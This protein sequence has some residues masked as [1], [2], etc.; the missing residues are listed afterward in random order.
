M[1]FRT[2][3]KETIEDWESDPGERNRP[4]DPAGRFVRR[5]RGRS[6]GLLILYPLVPDQAKSENGNVPILAFAI[7][8]PAV[9]GES[10]SKVVYTVNNVFQRLEFI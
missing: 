9:A 8:F 5:Y 2:A 7:S 6:R 4:T 1:A 10:A 3:L